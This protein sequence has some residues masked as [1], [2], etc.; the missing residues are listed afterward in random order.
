MFTFPTGDG[1][2]KWFPISAFFA[3]VNVSKLLVFISL[4]LVSYSPFFSFYLYIEGFQL[5]K[6]G[7]AYW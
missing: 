5:A 1:F 4:R 2:F 6:K 3:K 7:G